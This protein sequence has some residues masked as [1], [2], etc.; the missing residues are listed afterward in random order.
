MQSLEGIVSARMLFQE[1]LDYLEVRAYTEDQ[2]PL[3]PPPYV[4]SKP[5]C[6]VMLPEGLMICG[7]VDIGEAKCVKVELWAR[8]IMSM[9]LLYSKPKTGL[10][11]YRFAY[12]SGPYII[13]VDNASQSDDD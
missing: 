3:A 13:E 4:S 8:E 5:N 12:A 2:D 10:W 11:P 6:L 9:R 1:A 7:A